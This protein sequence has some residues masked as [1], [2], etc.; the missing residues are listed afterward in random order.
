MYVAVGTYKESH[1]EGS[2]FDQAAV[3]RF[4]IDND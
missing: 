4:A 3:Q 1:S 2:G